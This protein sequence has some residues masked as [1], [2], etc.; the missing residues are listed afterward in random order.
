MSSQRSQA[1][2]GRKQRRNSSV[3]Q[4]FGRISCGELIAPIARR[5]GARRDRHDQRFSRAGWT[6]IFLTLATGC[7]G[8]SSGGGAGTSPP[9]VPRSAQDVAVVA[10]GVFGQGLVLR[11]NGTDDLSVPGS[12]GYKFATQL[13]DGGTY[14]VS[15]YTQPTDPAEHC[16]LT[17]SSGTATSGTAINVIVNCALIVSGTYIGVDYANSGDAASYGDTVLD[18][19]GR[20]PVPR[21]RM[22]RASSPPASSIPARIQYLGQ[23]S[24]SIP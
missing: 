7:G 19:S 18:D 10:D 13:M 9:P 8:G 20:I 1:L 21:M 24:G 17:S 22:T 12:G 15:V 11:N 16:A 14:D 2:G 23:E 6:W 3:R 5:C 4:N